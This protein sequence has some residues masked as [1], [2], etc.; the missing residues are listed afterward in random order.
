MAPLMER[1]RLLPS[2]L[3]S[4]LL[5]SLLCLSQVSNLHPSPRVQTG[6]GTCHEQ[7]FLLLTDQLLFFLFLSL[8]DQFST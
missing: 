5:F 2:P 1:G 8:E 7:L 4:L 3:L 6:E